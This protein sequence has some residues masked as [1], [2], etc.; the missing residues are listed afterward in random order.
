M[1]AAW[2]DLPIIVLEEIFAMLSLRE[3]FNASQVCKNW[4]DCFYSPRVWEKLEFQER[5]FTKKIFSVYQGLQY[6]FNHRKFQLSL[7]RIG[8]FIK[9]IVVHPVGDYYNLYEF[10][11][12]LDTY[13]TFFP[14]NPMPLLKT[15]DFTFYC[16]NKGPAGSFVYGTGG[17]IFRKLKVLISHMPYLT[18]LKLQNV[19]LSLADAQNLLDDVL[20]NC[21]DT[22]KVLE[23]L[24]ITSEMCPLFQVGMFRN[25][26]RLVISPQQ[27]NEDLLLTIARKSI[28]ELHISQDQ[29]IIPNSITTPSPETWSEA[30]RLNSLLQVKLLCVGRSK[31]DMVWQEKA[32]VTGVI[33]DTVYAL[34]TPLSVLNVIDHYSDTLQVYGHKSLPRIHGSRAFNDRID[35]NILLLVRGCPKIHTLIIRDRIST[36]SI[37]LIASECKN[38]KRLYIRQNA[39]LKRMDW[40]KVP[41]W[42]NDFYWWLKGCSKSFDTMQAEV[43]RIIG[44]PWRA[45][46]DKEFISL[47]EY[48]I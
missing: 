19:L 13:L 36:A 20:N 5:S 40:S 41:E 43:S 47:S 29:Y 33:Y 28:N 8:A 27:L 48:D 10:M 17:N 6:R 45:L 44:Y 21:G 34:V 9:K 32:P 25:L 1:D 11:T 3:R 4:L 26:R 23:M 12:V 39:I 30:R 22:L 2:E 37:V 31:Y 46:T 14:D 35:S 7:G 42:S 18:N 16:E 24:N 38:L 15:F